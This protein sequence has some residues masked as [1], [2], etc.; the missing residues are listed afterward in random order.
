MKLGLAAWHY[1]HR[2]MVENTKYFLDNGFDYVSHLGMFFADL[3][4]D[5][6]KAFE[7]AN[8][9]C[10]KKMT[11]HFKLPADHSNETVEKFKNDILSIAKWQEKYHLIEILSFDVLDSIRDN[12]TPYVDFVLDNVK[13]TK[14]ALEDFGLNENELKQIEHLKGNEYFGYLLDI[15]HMFIRLSS[16]CVPK[17]TLFTSSIFE[18]NEVSESGFL[19]TFK[20]KTFP[21]FEMHLHNNDGITDL[22]Q[23]LENGE[24]DI[25]MVMNAIEKFGFNGYLTIESAPGFMFDC[26]GEEADNKIMQT[27]EYLKNI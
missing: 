23:F 26:K 17:E 19:N 15:G 16:K 25:K 2:T 22:H 1:P 5:E 9:L 21:V 24:L 18:C 4:K 3:I 6:N 27:F 8:A 11:V 14:I 12:I 10:G 20:S 13:N 7:L